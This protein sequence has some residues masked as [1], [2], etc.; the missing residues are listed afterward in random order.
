MNKTFQF[1]IGIFAVCL[2]ATS[3]AAVSQDPSHI[4][5]EAKQLIFV[6]TKTWDAVTGQLQRYQRN[7]TKAPWVKVGRPIPVVV[8]KAGLGW[9]ADYVKAQHGIGPLK[10]EGDNRTPAGI[11]ALGPAFGF[12]AKSPP[13][14]RLSY[15]PLTPSSVCVDDPRSQYYNW[16]FDSLK[17][18]TPPDW[19][20][21]EEMRTVAL[22][23]LGAVIQYNTNPIAQ[24]AGSC[25]FLHSWRGPNLGTA[26]CVAM[27]SDNLR[28]V[29][30][31]LVPSDNPVIE[32]VARTSMRELH[33]DP[34]AVIAMTSSQ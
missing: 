13:G 26:G 10:R 5:R 17:A 8:G 23:H 30:F 1:L 6:Q 20:S 21:A 11:Y 9:G 2:A 32:I 18:P 19:R 29:L 3:H 14:L 4:L 15:F 7:K 24:G 22:Y 31:W 33:P 27:H 28:T 12:D 34:G 25:V 16:V